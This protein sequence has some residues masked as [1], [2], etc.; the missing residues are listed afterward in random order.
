MAINFCS[1]CGAA[2]P[3]FRIPE[4]DLKPRHV[5]R[6]CG[7]I[8]YLN[9]KVVVGTLPRWKDQVLLCRRAIEP[10]YGLWTLPAGFLEIGE[11]IDEG[12]RRETLEEAN[13]AVVLDRLYTV[14]TVPRIGQLHLM[15][16][17]DLPHPEFFAG[18]E[19]LEARLFDEANIPWETIAFRTVSRTLRCFFWD[20]QHIRRKAWDGF[21]LRVSSL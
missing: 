8:H 1:Q 20:R 12:A 9:P 5:C 17:A 21:P 15:F 10:R 16:L 4:G 3:E 6:Q 14:I 19:T 11:S 18:E 13:A 2:S 7:H